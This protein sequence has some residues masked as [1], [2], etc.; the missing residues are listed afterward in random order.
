MSAHTIASRDTYWLC[1][2]APPLL[3]R[4]VVSE[5]TRLAVETI[6]DMISAGTLPATRLRRRVLV[7]RQAVLELLH[8]EHVAP[9]AVSAGTRPESD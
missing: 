6:D 1:N 7:P 4:S 2:A 3:A 5:V 9:T 8:L